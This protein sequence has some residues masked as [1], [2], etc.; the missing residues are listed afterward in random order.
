MYLSILNYFIDKIDTATGD[1]KICEDCRESFHTRKDVCHCG[2]FTATVN[3][4]EPK[5]G[6]EHEQNI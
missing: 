4:D 6:I 3:V 1:I 2:S 5:K